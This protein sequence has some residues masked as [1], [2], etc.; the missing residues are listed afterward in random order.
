[1]LQGVKTAVSVSW[2]LP[3]T[4]YHV[5]SLCFMRPGEKQMRST[6]PP[7]PCSA[8]IIKF[9][10]RL[11]RKKSKS[12]TCAML[13]SHVTRWVTDKEMTEGREQRIAAWLLQWFWCPWCMEHG[14]GRICASACLT[15]K[16][17]K[18]NLKHTKLHI[19]S[20]LYIRCNET[21]NKSRMI[22][23]QYTN[24]TWHTATKDL[25]TFLW[26]PLST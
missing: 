23:A 5:I 4:S 3:I 26:D 9:H 21:S 2:E 1:M 17:F 24:T 16:K 10:Y 15:K 18:G 19:V 22:S 25:K 8:I 14:S 7:P 11:G 12:N 6:P 13:P 20:H